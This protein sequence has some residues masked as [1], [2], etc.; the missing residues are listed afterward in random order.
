MSRSSRTSSD[1]GRRRFGRRRRRH[2]LVQLAQQQEQDKGHDQ[3]ID[4]GIDEQ[5][6]I[7]GDGLGGLGGGQGLD[8][9]VALQHH[10]EIGEIHAA[11]RQADR[12]HHHVIDQRGD[13]AGEGRA[14][15]H[16]DRQVHDIAAHG[17]F[18]EF[19]KIRD[20]R[21]VLAAGFA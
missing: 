4:D 6:V 7:D 16:T 14:D 8:A 9:G 10:E 18:L 1:G 17:E 20:M 11:Q 13:D 12:R 2:Q 3:E 19:R 15:D 21:R 5:A